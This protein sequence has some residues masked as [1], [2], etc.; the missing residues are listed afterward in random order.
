MNAY[1]NYVA[2][3]MANG[4]ANEIAEA[5]MKSINQEIDRCI[6]ASQ[7]EE[8]KRLRTIAKTMIESALGEAR[9]TMREHVARCIDAEHDALAKVQQHVKDCLAQQMSE[10][11]ALSDRA[12]LV[13][14]AM[15]EFKEAS[16]E[17]DES[18]RAGIAQYNRSL[19]LVVAAALGMQ[20]IGGRSEAEES[21]R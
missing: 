6:E 16:L 13:R 19:G 18:D 9:M 4:M 2:S 14:F 20:S 3:N 15:A 11:S 1:A 10:W 12:K 5:A 7:S 8:K 21:K 17:P